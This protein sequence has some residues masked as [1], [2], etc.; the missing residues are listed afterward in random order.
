MSIIHPYSDYLLAV[1]PDTTTPST[2]GQNNSDV[3]FDG[4]RDSSLSPTLTGN[5]TI[6]EGFEGKESRLM[7]DV[8]FMRAA[9]QSLPGCAEEVSVDCKE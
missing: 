8:N 9:M 4:N 3:N 6:F 1:E 5:C 2:K 7:S